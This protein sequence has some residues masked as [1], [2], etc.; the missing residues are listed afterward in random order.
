MKALTNSV[1]CELL[2]RAEPRLWTPSARELTPETSLGFECINFAERVLGMELYPWQKFFLIH[3]L[4]LN[5]DGSYRFNT[6]LLIVARQNGKTELLKLLA[7]WKLFMDDNR[8]VLG[9]AQTLDLAKESWNMCAETILDSPALRKRVS[10]KI[11]DWWRQGNNAPH[12]KLLTGARYQVI[13]TNRRARGKSTDT[14]LL[15]ELRE[16]RDEEA[17]AALANTTIAR[18]NHQKFLFTNAGDVESVVLN[19]LRAVALANLEGEEVTG[20]QPVAIFEWSAPEDADPEDESVWPM[21]NPSLGYTITVRTL[22]AALG[23]QSIERFKTENL[24]MPVDALNAAIDLGGWTSGTNRKGGIPAGAR[25]VSFCLD[26]SPDSL[27]VTLAAAQLTP[28]GRVWV[29]IVK[30]WKGKDAVQ[31][32]TADLA[33]WIE[34][35]RPRVLGWFPSGPGGVFSSLLGPDAKPLRGVEVRKIAGA[36]VAGVCMSFAEQVQARRISHAGDEL[37]NAHVTGAKKT[38]SGD[39]WRFQRRDDGRPVDAAYAAAGAI[40]IARTLPKSRGPMRVL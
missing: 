2:G 4:E 1:N 17:W 30:D 5:E 16:Q 20:E 9:A 37:L 11:S 13:S 3:A 10:A 14:L 19:N 32:A 28:Q 39:G 34:A 38:L 40:H 22:R 35:K 31:V 12:I 18:P 33:G 36:D 21:A 8:L 7:L 29:E 27:H 6:V 15:D 23:T 25:D 24:C 26:V